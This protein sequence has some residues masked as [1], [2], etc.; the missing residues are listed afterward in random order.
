ME[1]HVL[2]HKNMHKH[3]MGIFL[4]RSDKGT[5]S[6]LTLRGKRDYWVVDTG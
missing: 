5:T 3:A 6:P 2:V 4:A 1:L